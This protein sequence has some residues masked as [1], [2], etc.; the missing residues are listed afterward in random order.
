MARTIFGTLHSGAVDAPRDGT[1]HASHLVLHLG[2]IGSY[3]A[4]WQIGIQ[5]VAGGDGDG[6]GGGAFVWM[7][8]CQNGD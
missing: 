1:S 2:F 8:R 6:D 4:G 5:V 7:K 3:Q